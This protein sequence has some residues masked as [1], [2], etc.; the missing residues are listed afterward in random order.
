MQSQIRPGE[1]CDYATTCLD[2]A[3]CCKRIITPTSAVT[4]APVYCWPALK[5]TMQA[6][7]VMVQLSH[8]DSWYTVDELAL[9]ANC[10]W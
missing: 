10:C 9:Q 3:A 4:C 2:D 6:E 1:L 7:H 8:Q 5:V